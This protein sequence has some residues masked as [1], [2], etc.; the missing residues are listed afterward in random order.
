MTMR[1][2]MGRAARVCLILAGLAGTWGWAAPATGATVDITSR[3][4]LAELAGGSFA[5][6][7]SSASDGVFAE[8]VLVANGDASA[9]AFQGTLLDVTGGILSVAGTG[10]A[11]ASLAA[12]T[13]PG[14]DHQARSVLDVTF[15]AGA[16]AT[17]SA[18]GFLSADGAFASV[19]FLLEE[20]GGP[21]LLD[22][23]AGGAFAEAG[24]LVAGTQYRVLADALV[25]TPTM[26]SEAFLSRAEWTFDFA[27]ID[28]GGGD[29][30]PPPVVPLPSAAWGGLALLGLLAS[31]RL[32]R[33][34]RTTI[35]A[36]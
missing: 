9:L 11:E 35:L 3:Q 34:G 12:V 31:G 1:R 21:A 10:A 7:L 22:L 27:V 33:R 20:V 17:W 28:D 18:A 23:T 2:T 24:S 29:G 30:D 32:M 16:G 8:A 6:A 19:R 25:V 14:T 26:T 15:T 36:S 5:D 4:V 13:Q